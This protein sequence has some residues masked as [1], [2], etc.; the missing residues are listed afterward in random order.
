MKYPKMCGH[1]S[2]KL[3]DKAIS[4][5]V[6]FHTRVGAMPRMSA[7]SCMLMILIATS[8]WTGQRTLKV[9]LSAVPPSCFSQHNSLLGVI[10]RWRE[11]LECCRVGLIVL[12][13][14]GWW[15]FNF[16]GWGG[17]AGFISSLLYFLK[18]RCVA[19]GCV[20]NSRNFELWAKPSGKT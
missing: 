4:A 16:V 5:S 14:R 8:P 6:S 9:L 20:P 18:V 13:V 3:F 10:R 1:L 7:I 12:P 19:P 11:V 15:L 2:G 17:E